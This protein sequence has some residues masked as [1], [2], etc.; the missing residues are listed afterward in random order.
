M[1]LDLECYFYGYTQV[2]DKTF[3]IA[4]MIHSEMHIDIYLGR[5]H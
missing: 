1:L 4:A 3:V 5:E 2:L